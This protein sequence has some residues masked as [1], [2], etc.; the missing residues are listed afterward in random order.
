MLFTPFGRNCLLWP[1]DL[2]WDRR[3]DPGLSSSAQENDLGFAS[4]LSLRWT[5]GGKVLQVATLQQA[6]SCRAWV[7]G[8]WGLW[9]VLGHERRWRTKVFSL[10]FV[11]AFVWFWFNFNF[12][13]FCLFFLFSKAITLENNNYWIF[14]HQ[15]NRTANFLNW[16][17]SSSLEE[18]TIEH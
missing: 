1:P 18:I 11:W 8:T 7:N 14:A 17:H 10:L 16:K 5:E 6:H 12:W 9:R 2:C 4:N 3:T 13:L 15:W